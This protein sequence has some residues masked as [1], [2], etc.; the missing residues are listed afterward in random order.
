MF[1]L[2]AN[3]MCVMFR[4]VRIR[5]R[6]V[7]M[8][9]CALVLTG[10]ASGHYPINAPLDTSGTMPGT[11][12]SARFL[13]AQ[14]NSNSLLIAVAF[15]GGGF[16]ASALAYSVLAEL[17]AT[18]IDWQGRKKTMLDEVDFISGVSGG[19]ITAAYYALHGKKIFTSFNEAVLAQD[20]QAEMFLRSL[21]PRGMWR[22]SSPTFGRGD[23]LQELLD[24]KIF[25]GATF[26]DIPRR[27]PMVFITATDLE[28]GDRFEF[29][30]EQFDHLCADLNSVPLARAVAASAAVPILF[31]PITIWNHSRSCMAS[32]AKLAVPSRAAQSPYVHLVDGGLSDNSG[33]LTPIELIS[34]RGGIIRSAKAIGMK[35]IRKRVFIIVNSQVRPKYNDEN[36]PNT[37]GLLRQLQTAIDVPIDRYANA[38]VALLRR[39]IIR[40]RDELQR[41]TD[42]ELG[43]TI[44]RNTEFYVIEVSFQSMEAIIDSTSLQNIST[45]LRM[46]SRDAKSIDVFARDAL[47]RNPE[48]QR[49]LRDIQNDA[50]QQ[51]SSP[52][53]AR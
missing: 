43:D 51:S 40:W 38:S 48:W 41:A 49:L 19:S 50:Q 44:A 6:T 18:P 47:R 27:K 24:E 25:R 10:C 7:A 8:M 52:A 34:T 14:G 2:I 35:G 26:Q 23:I 46:S 12:Y 37:P 20:I 30:Q 36:S 22:Q 33:I 15:S 21:S 11:P 3:T 17:E 31:S 29:S 13:E 28:F 32:P 4:R 9:A 45:S 5:A 16:R 53:G 1:F 39:E 42:E